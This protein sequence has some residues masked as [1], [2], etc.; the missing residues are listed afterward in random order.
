MSMRS[1]SIVF[2]TTLL[3]ALSCLLFTGCRDSGTEKQSI[4]TASVTP[5]TRGDLS[6][7]LVV[8]GEFQPYQEVDLHAKVYGYVRR[9]NVDIGDRVKAG[10]VIATL[11][12]PELTA[13]VAG[14]QA[15]V[16]HS[17][18]EIARAQSG[19]AL[20]E[21][22]YAAVHAAY[23]RLSEASKQRPGLVAEQELDDSRA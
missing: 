9:I 8:A 13:Q 4:P 1:Q 10:Q 21:A 14:S 23:T 7:T 3:T 6:S 20:A 16:R 2:G 11:E 12:V 15:E 17:Q 22:N 5:V 19:V 18:S